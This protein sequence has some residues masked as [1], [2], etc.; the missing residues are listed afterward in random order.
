MHDG[1]KG[2]QH[3]VSLLPGKRDCWQVGL[4]DLR[5]NEKIKGPEV[6]TW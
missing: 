2:F 5:H 3:S 1:T 6:L 4:P